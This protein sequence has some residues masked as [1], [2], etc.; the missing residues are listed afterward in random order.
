MQQTKFHI[1]RDYCF[2]KIQMSNLVEQLDEPT[3]PTDIY[4][5]KIEEI[6]KTLAKM[7]DAHPWIANVLVAMEGT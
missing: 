1:L 7:E 2:L 6:N 4:Q 3:C 5:D